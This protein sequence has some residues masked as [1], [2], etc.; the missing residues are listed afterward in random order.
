M[1]V[2]INIINN[3]KGVVFI[4]SGTVKGSEIIEA[5]EKVYSPELLLNLEYK[6]IDRTTCTEYLVTTEE[7]ETI[8]S[9]DIEASKINNNITVLLV[10][11]TDLQFGMTRMWQALSESTGWHSEIFKTREE[12]NIY[13]DNELGK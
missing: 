6:I 3:G 10:S 7:M 1:P 4:S 11:S 5:N 12:A 8:S 13:M 2:E 9:Q